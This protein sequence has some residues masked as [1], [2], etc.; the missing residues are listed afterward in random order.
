MLPAHASVFAHRLVK[1]S[2]RP[3]R[4]IAADRILPDADFGR[5]MN[6]CD[7][8][9]PDEVAA[10]V[11]QA[12]VSGGALFAARH[13]YA[14]KADVSDPLQRR[15]AVPMQEPGARRILVGGSCRVARAVAVRV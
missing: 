7:W 4:C 10:K 3:A 6:P 1:Q 8:N 14:V 2:E 9:A 13:Q 12:D 15:A 11:A 5:Y